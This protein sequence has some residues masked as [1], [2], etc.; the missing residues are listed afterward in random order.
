MPSAPPPRRLKRNDASGL[1]NAAPNFAGQI[2]RGWKLAVL[3]WRCIFLRAVQPGGSGANAR[4][5]TMSQNIRS[6]VKD[7][8]GK[9]PATFSKI[10]RWQPDRPDGPMPVLV[11]VAGTFNGWQHVALKRD[12]ASGV[13]Q[14][15]LN[16]I[17][18]HRTHNY[19]LLVNGKPAQDKNADGLA[20]PHTAEE[21]QHQ[22]RHRAGRACSCSS[23]RQNSRRFSKT[24][25]A[26]GEGGTE[27]F[28]RRL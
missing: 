10:F 11:E 14:L 22:L 3:P 1:L 28:C 23:A 17:P 16:D 26:F 6:S 12:R 21:K 13:W 7:V 15:T 24:M 20:V 18:G 25:P 2:G 19:M 8:A 27:N 4:C 9:R 5:L